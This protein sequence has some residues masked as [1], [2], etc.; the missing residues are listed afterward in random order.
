M[1]VVPAQLGPLS[2]ALAEYWLE[3]LKVQYGGFR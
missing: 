3:I 2:R 1:G